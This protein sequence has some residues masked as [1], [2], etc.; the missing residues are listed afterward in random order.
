MDDLDLHARSGLPDALRVLVEHYPRA[1]WQG[2]ANF[3]GLTRFWLDR[4]L[5]FRRLQARLIGE[6]RG[7][8]D[9]SVEA[10]RAAAG[11]AR[12]GNLFLSELSAHHGVED[13]HYFPLLARL[14][15]GL[16]AGFALLDRD[17]HRLDG[18]LHALAE[19]ANDA[20]RGLQAPAGEAAAG[21]AAVGR[22]EAR[23]TGFERF[24]DRH[25][26][27]EEEIVVPVILKHGA[28]LG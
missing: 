26:V 12:L 25:L 9:G 1:R 15:P 16:H 5:M 27:D 4:H 3:D 10:R 19:T 6:A 2:H 14:E 23:L 17:H 22:L 18:D 28:G 13:A 11:I 20:L 7:F 8:L 21:R 24:L